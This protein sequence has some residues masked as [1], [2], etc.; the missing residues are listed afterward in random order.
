[1]ADKHAIREGGDCCL[2]LLAIE[3]YKSPP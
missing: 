2:D 1:M 3:G